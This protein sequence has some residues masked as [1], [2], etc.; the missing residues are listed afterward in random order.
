MPARLILAVAL[1]GLAILAAGCGSKKQ[2][3]ATQWAN[4]FCSAVSTW[5]DSL[6]TAASS[7]NAGNVS[8]DTLQSA[9]D[10]AKSATDKFVSKVRGLGKPP[11]DAG[12]KAQQEINDLSD[13]IDAGTKTIQDATK[14]V[15]GITG[16][17]S[18]VSTVT[19]TLSTMGTQVQTTYENLRQLDP[20]GELQSAFHDADACQNLK[21]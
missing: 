10:D 6:Q 14:N 18:A 19:A 21:S 2:P 4:D 5:R 17:L 16:A 9:A 12:D 20:Q 3:T 1:A 7:V 11:T 13:E 15:Q 8:K